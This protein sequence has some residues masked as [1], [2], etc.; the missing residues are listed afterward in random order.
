M[1]QHSSVSTGCAVLAEVV[2]PLAMAR[3]RVA[4]RNRRVDGCQSRWSS[5]FYALQNFSS[6]C[7]DAQ[8]GTTVLLV[9]GY[10]KVISR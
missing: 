7:P 2:F 10:Q 6:L 8:Q 4:W 9:S 1:L 3:V 5:I